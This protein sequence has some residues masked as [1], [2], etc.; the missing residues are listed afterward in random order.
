VTVQIELR[1]PTLYVEHIAH[2][3]E[4]VLERLDGTD[5]PKL[6]RQRL[7]GVVDLDGVYETARA[8]AVGRRVAREAMRR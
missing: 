8:Q 2:E 6:A 5:L 4:H 1:T 7:D 3:V